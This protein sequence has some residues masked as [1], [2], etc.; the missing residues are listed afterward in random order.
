MNS[1]GRSFFVPLSSFWPKILFKPDAHVESA[2]KR[3]HC[4]MK[5]VED[6]GLDVCYNDRCGLRACPRVQHAALRDLSIYLLTSFSTIFSP[7][8]IT[9]LKHLT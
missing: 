9:G 1:S 2:V 8:S 6:H 5:H 3:V 7:S 4:L